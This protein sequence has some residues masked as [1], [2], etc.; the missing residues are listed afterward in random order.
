LVVLGALAVALAHVI[1]GKALAPLRKVRVWTSSLVAGFMGFLVLWLVLL[2]TV[3]HNVGPL[4]RCVALPVA[5]MVGCEV[6]L[7]RLDLCPF[8]GRVSIQ[9]LRVENPKVFVAAKPEV[10]GVTPL[11][12]LDDF[13]VH[14]DVPTLFKDGA[15][16]TQDVRVK[17]VTLKGLR[18]LVA[19]DTWSE[20]DTDYVVTNID[21]LMMQMGL[22]GLPTPEVLAEEK[23]AAA[24]AEATAQ[25]QTEKVAAEQAAQVEAKRAALDAELKALE[26]ET[27]Q[28]VAEGSLSRAEATE[29]VM[30]KKQ[31]IRETLEAY[32]AQWKTKVTLEKLLI[33]DNSVT[34]YWGHSFLP[35]D[36]KIPV[37]F[38]PLSLEDVS[39]EEVREMIEPALDAML[40]AYDLFEGFRLNVLGGLSDAFGALQEMGAEALDGVSNAMSNVTDATMDS[41][42]KASSAGVEAVSSAFSGVM[43]V[44][45]SESTTEE[46][47][48]AAVSSAKE[49][50]KASLKAIGKELK[51]ES[52][53]ATQSESEG[54]MNGLKNLKKLW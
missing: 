10:Y 16:S 52:K 43:D 9:G 8:E 36:P 27:E 31:S 32:K 42:S 30:A 2:N 6:A 4:V 54:L 15:F 11:F 46:D 53:D 37:A 34:F 5:K 47:K 40:A 28:A 18:V 19:W 7:D 50:L 23:A 44:F 14:V 51:Q 3:F 39:T 1:P 45:T 38:P 48:K 17:N 20:G 49:D 26:A 35:I 41:V 21:G 24:Q 12:K 29:Q 33:E 22:K 13:T 25:A